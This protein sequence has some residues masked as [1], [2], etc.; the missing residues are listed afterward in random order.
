M[1]DRI[2]GDRT[3]HDRRKTIAM[4]PIQT[5]AEPVLQEL[6]PGIWRRSETDIDQMP[7]LFYDG[8]WRDYADGIMADIRAFADFHPVDDQRTDEAIK[9]WS[10]Q[11]A[12][13]LDGEY[14][15]SYYRVAVHVGLLAYVRHMRELRQHIHCEQ[16]WHRIVERFHD[17]CS[18]LRGY[19][20]LGTH[21]KWGGLRFTYR[22]DDEANQ[23]CR[24]AELI[25]GERASVTCEVCGSP[26][27][28][29]WTAWR[30]TLC[31]QHA[32]SRDE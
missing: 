28:L 26:G 8:A 23:A 3:I 4:E 31:D 14:S 22:C 15:Q 7:R 13:E 16:G 11:C 17:A 19:G 12:D 2:V 27:E 1:P 21:E 5:L 20:F 10:R 29:R 25:A 30:K 18:G 32:R 6:Y 9:A 24:E